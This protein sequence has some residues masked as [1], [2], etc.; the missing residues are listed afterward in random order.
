MLPYYSNNSST[1]GLPLGLNFADEALKT[2][3]LPEKVVLQL[4]QSLALGLAFKVIVGRQIAEHLF[5][6]ITSDYV[7]NGQLQ[8]L[9]SSEFTRRRGSESPS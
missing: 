9:V 4:P 5:M 8:E 1:C 2:Y 6:Q 7:N 3:Y